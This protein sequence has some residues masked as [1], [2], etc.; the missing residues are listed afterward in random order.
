MSACEQ[1]GSCPYFHTFGTSLSTACFFGWASLHLEM[2][3]LSK[4][5]MGPSLVMLSPTS[6]K[7]TWRPGK[8]HRQGGRLSPAISASL[9]SVRFWV[10]LSMDRKQVCVLLLQYSYDAEVPNYR[11]TLLT[12]SAKAWLGI[13]AKSWSHLCVY[14]DM[15]AWG[16]L[17]QVFRDQ[18]CN[19]KYCIL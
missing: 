10:C 14:Q 5:I 7:V 1:Q 18:G 6:V 19:L 4:S 13:C 2:I 16:R 3:W 9:A 8:G 17:M 11:G 12:T 15:G